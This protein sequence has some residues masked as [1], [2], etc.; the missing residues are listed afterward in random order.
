MQ[1]IQATYESVLNKIKEL[2][3]IG[4]ENN[5][6]NVMVSSSDE[7]FT[8]LSGLDS[9]LSKQLEIKKINRYNA[10]V[11]TSHFPFIKTIEDFDFTFQP[12][13]NRNQIM[14]LLSLRFMTSNENVVFIGTP[15]TGKTH[16]AVAIGIEALKTSKRTYFI[17]CKDLVF[18]LEK[19]RLENTL[20]K[21][22]K[23]F[24][25]HSLLIIDELGHDV[26]TDN[27]ANDL[28]LLLQ[29]R[30]EKHSTIITTN[31]QFYQWK[32]IFGSNK[33]A[34]DATLDRLLHH[35]NIVM[36]EGPSYRLKDKTQYLKEEELA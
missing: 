17:S 32:K 27:E 10:G 34:L 7:D 33:I 30:Y 25:S 35:S 18:Q 20:D 29:L 4:F 5:L 11:K 14:N 3:L 9:L 15:G 6:Q 21:R 12:S 26:L 28:F 19:A 1:L 23:V 22:L 13:I 36:M 16:M 8:F 31:Y 24:A 2:N